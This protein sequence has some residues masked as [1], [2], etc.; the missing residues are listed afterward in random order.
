MLK[1]TSRKVLNGMYQF[2][3]GEEMIYLT[4]T[5][6]QGQPFV[7]IN[8]ASSGQQ[9]MLW[10]LNLMYYYLHEN[11]RVFLII[12]E[13]E[14]HLYPSSQATIADIIGIFAG[15]G[16]GN[17]AMVTTH[18]PY[19]LGEINN[20]IMCSQA[21]SLG[22]KVDVKPKGMWLD[23]DRTKAFHVRNGR[24]ENA[25]ADDGTIKNELIDG[26]SIDINEACDTLIDLI[27]GED[28]ESGT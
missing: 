27:Y 13:P 4:P 17:N 20:L 16:S 26:A 24:I 9:E 14:A 10:L 21:D 6:E 5:D 15:K 19:I 7:K 12:E 11:N 8:F 23:P 1:K 28:E 3:D 18:S 25:L 2:S 22:K